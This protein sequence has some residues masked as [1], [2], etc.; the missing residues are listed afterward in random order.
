MFDMF[1]YQV[2]GIS[3]GH[4]A[5]DLQ[6][7]A[8]AKLSKRYKPSLVEYHGKK[9]SLKKGLNRILYVAKKVQHS[10]NIP[11]NILQKCYQNLSSE[12]NRCNMLNEEA[13]RVLETLDG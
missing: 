2:D 11:E 5:A 7:E 10:L 13:L 9:T 12:N 4:L 8:L 3:K 1:Y 6:T